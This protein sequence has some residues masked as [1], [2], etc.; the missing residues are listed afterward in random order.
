MKLIE[1]EVKEDN[2]QEQIIIP[3]EQR[4]LAEEEGIGTGNKEKVTAQITNLNTGEIYTGR[5]AI[6]GTNQIYVP[7]EIQKM[8][9]K[10]GRIRI[11]ILGG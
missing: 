2:Y 5:L 6:T 9:D 7:V 8:L 1:W 4:K 3:S 10:S 11:Q